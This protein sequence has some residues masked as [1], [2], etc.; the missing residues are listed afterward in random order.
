MVLMSRAGVEV[1]VGVEVEGEE[2]MKG[3][4]PR[5]LKAL[6]LKTRYIFHSRESV[7][8]PRSDR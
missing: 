8:L 4:C 7:C 1:G 5:K 3:I 2:A 6:L